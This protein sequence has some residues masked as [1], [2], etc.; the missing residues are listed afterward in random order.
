MASQRTTMIQIGELHWTLRRGV[1]GTAAATE[2][3]KLAAELREFA[4]TT[5][6]ARATGGTGSHRL[7]LRD[8]VNRLQPMLHER[9]IRTFMD[10]GVATWVVQHDSPLGT[11]ED[12]LA[13][14]EQLAARANDLATHA[15]RESLASIDRTI[16]GGKAT[17]PRTVGYLTLVE[18]L[19]SGGMADV[20]RAYDERLGRDVAV[21]F[22]KPEVL[23]MR[24]GR[25]RFQREAKAAAQL[26]HPNVATVYDFNIE[27]EEPYLVQEFV[28]GD[29]LKT[30][31]DRGPLPL[32]EVRDVAF[33]LS[34]AIEHAH[35]KPLVHRDIKP[36]NLRMTP[37]KQLKLIDFGLA[38]F[39]AATEDDSTLQDL[40][41][42]Y[43]VGTVQY[44]APE[45]RMNGEATPASDIYAFGITIFEMATGKKPKLPSTL[46]DMTSVLGSRLGALIHRCCASDPT[47]RPTAAEMRAELSSN[48]H[49]VV[50]LIQPLPILH[51]SAPRPLHLP[52][53][54]KST[55][56]HEW[57]RH[58]RSVARDTATKA[59]SIALEVAWI[60][61][62][63]S[64]LRAPELR[65]I[66]KESRTQ[67]LG[68]MI[69][70]FEVG[71]RYEPQRDEDGLHVTINAGLGST[72]W[73]ARRTGEYLYVAQLPYL[74][75]EAIPA[76]H[77]IGEVLETL[78]FFGRLATYRTST[79]SGT[80]EYVLRGVS[81]RPLGS[82]N[83]RWAF[84]YHLR[85]R[86]SRPSVDQI[87][88]TVHATVD[89]LRNNLGSIAKEVLDDLFDYFAVVIPDD[90]FEYA[91]KEIS[92]AFEQP[93]G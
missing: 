87:R 39:M 56:D 86:S 5:R 66:L 64:E 40:T 4:A 43:A 28:P 31:L 67:H 79:T 65:R 71:G 17:L 27:A 10:D 57:F 76:D 29:D 80:V 45:L 3:T 51:A 52:S 23:A 11:G 35:E 42:A 20:Y 93:G 37:D 70:R 72:Y 83:N 53:V 47:N 74:T 24:H 85:S 69:G 32:D 90:Y 38:K 33:Q 62:D 21:K 82:N 7:A 61:N 18:L 89:Q 1:D 68:S 13:F 30:I 22:P 2:F 92:K 9:A 25:E 55:F 41:G 50:T 34:A 49:D 77:I 19:G 81:S 15:M 46:E 88:T 58:H 60:P 63:P 12:Y 14:L 78:W 84:T 48:S 91:V 6:Q 26:K 73:A 8:A 44:M 16:P 36:A 59:H 75:D 54:M